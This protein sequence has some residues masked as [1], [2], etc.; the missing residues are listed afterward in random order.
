M[1]VEQCAHMHIFR[2]RP[3]CANCPCALIRTNTV[4]MYRDSINIDRTLQ[5]VKYFVSSGKLALWHPT[6]DIKK[7]EHLF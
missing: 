2:K 6:N 7:L 1:L 3:E 5:K 4:Y